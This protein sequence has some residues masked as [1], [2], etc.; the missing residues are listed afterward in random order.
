MRF[1]GPPEGTLRKTSGL[2]DDWVG[3][4]KTHRNE[5]HLFVKERLE[6]SNY[7]NAHLYRVMTGEFSLIFNTGIS[8]SNPPNGEE[9]WKLCS[10]PGF[11][12]TETSKKKATIMLIYFRKL[13]KTDSTQEINVRN[14]IS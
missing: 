4:Y 14:V 1:F 5:F 2:K 7:N 13:R 6:V 9:R 12:I 3:L 10:S 8:L 11:A